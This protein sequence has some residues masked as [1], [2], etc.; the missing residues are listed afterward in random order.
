M[1]FADLL[2]PS[3]N[4]C[5]HF[6]SEVCDKLSLRMSASARKVETVPAS[7]KPKTVR[8]KPIH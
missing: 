7:L 4:S 8:L 6:I 3:R 5:L 1:Q 2:T